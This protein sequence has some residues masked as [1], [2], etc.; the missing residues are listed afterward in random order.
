MSIHSDDDDFEVIDFGAVAAGLKDIDDFEEI[1]Y[2]PP[3]LLEQSFLDE[4][5]FQLPHSHPSN[6]TTGN[7]SVRVR[8]DSTCSKSSSSG[9]GVVDVK[10]S[11]RKR[12]QQISAPYVKKQRS[13]KDI[14]ASKLKQLATKRKKMKEQRQQRVRQ[15]RTS[16][17]SGED[18]YEECTLNCLGDDGSCLPV[19]DVESEVVVKQAVAVVENVAAPLKSLSKTLGSESDDCSNM[20]IKSSDNIFRILELDKQQRQQDPEVLDP[21][22]EKTS[23]VSEL[24]FRDHSLGSDPS[25]SRPESNLD[26]P[27]MDDDQ[28]EADMSRHCL[29]DEKNTENRKVSEPVSE[30]IESSVDVDFKVVCSKNASVTSP[31]VIDLRSVSSSTLLSANEVEVTQQSDQTLVD[32]EVESIMC[33]IPCIGFSTPKLKSL[34]PV[35]CCPTTG[36]KVSKISKEENK[37]SVTTTTE[38][39]SLANDLTF[40]FSNDEATIAENR[41]NLKGNAVVTF[42]GLIFNEN[43]KTQDGDTTTTKT[44]LGPKNEFIV[45]STNV[46]Q[47]P[48]LL[49]DVVLPECSNN[50]DVISKDEQKMELVNSSKTTVVEEEG[51]AKAPFPSSSTKPNYVIPLSDTSPCVTQQKQ[52]RRLSSNEVVT[53]TQ[54]VDPKLF[55]EDSMDSTM[56]NYGLKSGTIKRVT[57][58]RRRLNPSEIVTLSEI[59]VD[60]DYFSDT[61]DD[62]ESRSVESSF[63][64]SPLVVTDAEIATGS[65]QHEATCTL[66]ESSFGA[67]ESKKPKHRGMKT[68]KRLTATTLSKSANKDEFSDEDDDSFQSWS[69]E[70]AYDPNKSIVVVSPPPPPSGKEEK[71]SRKVSFSDHRDLER[72][73]IA[74]SIEPVMNN[75]YTNMSTSTVGLEKHSSSAD[76]K[77]VISTPSSTVSVSSTPDA[78]VLVDSTEVLENAVDVAQ[79]KDETV[80]E[81]SCCDGDQLTIGSDTNIVS[82]PDS[83]LSVS[84]TPDGV[85]GSMGIDEGAVISTRKQ[86]ELLMEKSESG[87]QLTMGNTAS[88]AHATSTLQSEEAVLE[89]ALDTDQKK[90]DETPKKSGYGDGD[91]LPIGSD[92]YIVS[93]PDSAVSVDLMKNDEDTATTDKPIKLLKENKHRVLPDSDKKI[94]RLKKEEVDISDDQITRAEEVLNPGRVSNDSVDSEQLPS[95]LKEVS[96][97]SS[98]EKENVNSA[99]DTDIVSNIEC[100]GDCS[101]N[102]EEVNK[103]LICEKASD[104]S[105]TSTKCC[106]GKTSVEESNE[107]FIRERVVQSSVADDIGSSGERI[108]EGETEK[109][110]FSNE[111]VCTVEEEQSVKESVEQL[112]FPSSLEDQTDEEFGVNTPQRTPI[113]WTRFA[114]KS[115]HFYKMFRD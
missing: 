29:S 72:V 38:E 46:Q 49:N 35:S 14:T 110:V 17:T 78:V 11:S 16:P 89:N 32:N 37:L 39:I 31:E 102:P 91:Q 81:S 12:N 26:Q 77:N 47:Q 3:D 84:S 68:K 94:S 15:F 33:K 108:P 83:A 112:Q 57:K 20:S 97:E 7:G 65:G 23:S 115:V 59:P 8:H 52:P 109:K 64:G 93:A 25:R 53:L 48:S 27:A 71:N 99:V 58:K 105:V 70:S 79:K 114:R 30:T 44:G 98:P 24:S 51:I 50:H 10:S 66:R 6:S 96:S 107:K 90:E 63:A 13:S 56:K 18:N 62:F 5:H 104:Q 101:R 19:K 9:V 4:D 40:P 75:S 2:Q 69:V 60:R 103:E 42:T 43:M 82:A 88:D 1:S 28:G 111:K 61:D 100:D 22:K 92:T 55:S 76:D 36:S 86:N 54:K 87:N 21:E 85:V 113:E 34:S 74:P 73:N 45:P 80:K 67:E 41:P 95:Q 106:Y